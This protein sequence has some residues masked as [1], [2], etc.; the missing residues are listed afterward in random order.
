MHRSGV[1]CKNLTKF[2]HPREYKSVISF[3]KKC[4]SSVSAVKL[5]FFLKKIML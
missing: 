4:R 3:L 1:I 5:V 2:T